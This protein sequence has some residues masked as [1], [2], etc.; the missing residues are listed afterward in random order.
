MIYASILGAL[1]TLALWHNARAKRAH[2]AQLLRER[3][4]FQLAQTDQ[5]NTLTTELAQSLKEAVEHSRQRQTVLESALTN[6]L[7]QVR[8]VV[9]Y[10][11]ERRVEAEQKVLKKGLS[12]GR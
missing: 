11:E 8:D 2:E 7:A 3:N 1:V 4:D 12:N 9:K 6:F 10:S 5:S